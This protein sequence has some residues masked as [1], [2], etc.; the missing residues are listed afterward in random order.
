[1]SNSNTIN[2]QRGRQTTERTERP[3]RTSM[4]GSRMRMSI[5]AEDQDPNF[6]YAWINDQRGLLQRAHRAGYEHVTTKEMPTWGE[7]GV[8]SSNSTSSV[9]QTNVGNGVTAYLMKQPMEYH[10][11]DR[12]EMDDLIDSREADMKKQLNSGK[13]GTYGKVEFE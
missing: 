5:D 6:H 4:S 8:E 2:K 7:V 11:E 10:L 12:K 9:V 1:M 3:K 13:E